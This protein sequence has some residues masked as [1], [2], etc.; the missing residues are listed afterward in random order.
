MWKKGL[1]WQVEGRWL[2]RTWISFS[3]PQ[4]HSCLAVVLRFH[5]EQRSEK[6]GADLQAASGKGSKFWLETFFFF[7]RCSLTKSLG[8]VQQ[9]IGTLE[10][11]Q[12]P[13]LLTERSNISFDLM[14]AFITYSPPFLQHPNHHNGMMNTFPYPDGNDQNNS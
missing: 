14:D 2:T 12:A 3:D 1:P 7:S 5:T 13:P 4:A 11:D 8:G 9:P 6:W 10:K